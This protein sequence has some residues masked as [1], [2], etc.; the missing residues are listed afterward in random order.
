MKRT[1]INGQEVLH[2][3]RSVDEI[4]GEVAACISNLLGEM[5][6]ADAEE[7]IRISNRIM[8][9]KQYANEI[10]SNKNN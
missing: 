3:D 1:L 10:I 9:I 7:K 8:E 2:D 6:Y 4:I 5:L